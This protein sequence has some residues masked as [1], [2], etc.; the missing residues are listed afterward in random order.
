MESLG[1]RIKR[2]SGKAESKL[3]EELYASFQA[4]RMRLKLVLALGFFRL[5]TFSLL[6]AV[7]K[8]W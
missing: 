8:T 4:L 1:Q 5:P 7:P 2:H 6:L 3:V